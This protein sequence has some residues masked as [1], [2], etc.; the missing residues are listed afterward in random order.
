M[1][2]MLTINADQYT[3]CHNCE[4]ACSMNHSGSFRPEVTRIHVYTWEREGFSVPMMCQHCADAPCITIRT[5][6][7]HKRA[8]NR[9]P[10]A[11][12][13]TLAQLAAVG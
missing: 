8:C 10:P 2:K 1:P 5:S 12:L 13:I 9:R 7:R 4:L 6:R 11:P 3:G